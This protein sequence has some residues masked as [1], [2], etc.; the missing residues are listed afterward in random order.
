VG[1]LSPLSTCDWPGH[2]AATVFCQGCPLRCGYCHNPTLQPVASPPE[3]AWAE[4]LALLDRRRG[5]LDGVVFSG[6]EPTLQPALGAAATDVR[7]AGFAVGLHTS[8]THPRRLHQVLPLLDWVGLDVKAP[9]RLYPDV[10][11]SATVATRALDSLRTVLAGGTP[12]EVR[13]TLH[14]ALDA[15]ALTELA[16]LLQAEGATTVALQACRS[17]DGRR[18]GQRPQD[19]PERVLRRW[20][21]AFP[22]LTLRE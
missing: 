2:L 8:G 16:D 10:T 13:I 5:L 6:G 18:L 21:R 14:P 4:V 20:T 22:A 1:G 19:L 9:P 15:E 11:G 12:L 3:R 7:A 17:H